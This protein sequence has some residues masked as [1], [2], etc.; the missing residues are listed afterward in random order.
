LSVDILGA[1]PFRIVPGA[2]WL[3][4]LRLLKLARVGQLIGRWRQHFLQH[5]TTLLLGFFVFWLLLIAHWLACGW[6]ALGGIEGQFDQTTR[7]VRALYWCITTL[8]TVGYGDIVPKTNAQTIYAMV[9]MLLGV[10]I[11]GYVVGNVANLLANLDRAK[12][13]HKD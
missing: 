7:Y 3:E 13:H 10:G 6:L 5:G 12:R 8:A 4:V 2:G 9:C 1:I 11:Y